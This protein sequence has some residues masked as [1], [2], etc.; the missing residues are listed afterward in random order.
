MLTKLH[1]PRETITA[2]AAE[3]RA[4]GES[5]K[6]KKALEQAEKRRDEEI[7]KAKIAAAMNASER[8]MREREEKNKLPFGGNV[9]VSAFNGGFDARVVRKD[10]AGAQTVS[11]LFF[12]VSLIDRYRSLG[13]LTPLPSTL[14][15]EPADG[16]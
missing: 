15:T 13:S 2:R 11:L 1:E 14:D 16:H 10:S 5:R 6:E 7:G 4:E 8:E 12:L 3:K 9:E